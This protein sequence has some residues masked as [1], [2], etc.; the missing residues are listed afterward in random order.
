MSREVD[1]ALRQ[2]DRAAFEDAAGR[3]LRLGDSTD[4][5]LDTEAF[6]RLST[7]RAQALRYGGTK[8]ERLNCLL[9]AM[10]LVTS[11]AGD[12]RKSDELHDYAF[13]AWSGMMATYS[14]GR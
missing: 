9:N 10:T 2:R 5:L 13:K 4:R 6:F 14:M 11:W 3:F 1:A 12:D 8:A 7:Y